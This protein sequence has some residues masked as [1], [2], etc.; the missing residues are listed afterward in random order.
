MPKCCPSLPTHADDLIWVESAAVP[1][2]PFAVL[3][4]LYETRPLSQTRDRSRLFLRRPPPTPWWK[5]LWSPRRNTMPIVPDAARNQGGLQIARAFQHL[6]DT[7][8]LR[9]L[10]VTALRL[11]DRYHVLET[12]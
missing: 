5:R 2:R 10:S 1:G 9:C 11:I 7:T 6:E 3:T 12:A 8:T 4:H